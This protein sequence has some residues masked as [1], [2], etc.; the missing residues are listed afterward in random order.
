MTGNALCLAAWLERL[1]VSRLAREGLQTDH[2][3]E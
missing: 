3:L 2:I 1:F